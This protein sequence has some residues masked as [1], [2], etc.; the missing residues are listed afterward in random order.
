M[1]YKTISRNSTASGTQNSTSYN[2]TVAGDIITAF[3]VYDNGKTLSSIT[4]GGQ[5]MTIHTTQNL[6]SEGY[7]ISACSLAGTTSGSKAVT[8]S[9]TGGTPFFQ[10]AYFEGYTG[11]DAVNATGGA[12]DTGGS[13][14][15]TTTA[16]NCWIAAGF[17]TAN[18]N[19]GWSDGTNF[20][21]QLGVASA[22]G[23]IGD[24]NASLGTAGA[25]TVAVNTSG[26][27]VSRVGLALSPALIVPLPVI[28]TI[29][30]QAVN[31]SYS[32]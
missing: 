6:S 3:V 17:I 30:R 29:K 27:N 19:S 14:S 28:S 9:F 4:F 23:K 22:R 10:Q 8:L 2:V 24:S 1:A 25:K 11:A 20:V 15:I 7:K 13:I 5:A 21:T 16:D 26:Y 32:Y 31:R 12:T 18:A